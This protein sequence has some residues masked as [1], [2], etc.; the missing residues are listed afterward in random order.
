MQLVQAEK[1]KKPVRLT[2]VATTIRPDW[3]YRPGRSPD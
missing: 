1:T 3:H 2:L